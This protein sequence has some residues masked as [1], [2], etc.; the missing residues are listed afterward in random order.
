M[1]DGLDRLNGIIRTVFNQYDPMVLPLK[2]WLD[3]R[4]VVFKL[5]ARV[6]DLDLAFATGRPWWIA[7]SLRS[8][9]P[10]QS[11]SR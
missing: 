5:G 11:S 6:T 3:G 10:R 4:G 1:V 7:S 8:Q 2:K 9:A